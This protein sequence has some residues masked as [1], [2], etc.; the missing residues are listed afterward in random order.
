MLRYLH[1]MDSI[2]ARH[3]LQQ[4]QGDTETALKLYSDSLEIA[5]KL[6]EL[7]PKNTEWQRMLELRASI[8]NL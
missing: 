6:V 2:Y 7:D 8:S 5:K 1:L 4:E 3:C